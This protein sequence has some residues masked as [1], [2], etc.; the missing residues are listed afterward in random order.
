MQVAFNFLL[1]PSWRLIWRMEL[2]VNL[3]FLLDRESEDF[4]ILDRLNDEF[5]SESSTCL[6]LIQG[7][8]IFRVE[9]IKT[10]RQ[11]IHAFRQIEGVQTVFSI[12]ESIRYLL[13]AW[14]VQ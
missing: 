10:L 13:P 12:D 6:M 11:M 5:G 3:N 2:A 7:Q 8:N 14:E 9:F 4:A 1:L